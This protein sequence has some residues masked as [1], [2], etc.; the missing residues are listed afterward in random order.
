MTGVAGWNR[1][2]SDGETTSVNTGFGAHPAIADL[3]D[4]GHPE[5]LVVREYTS[6]LFGYGDFSVVMLD[7]EGNI[8]GESDRFVEG[9]MDY[10]TGVAVSMSA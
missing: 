4:D 1:A 5:V 7:Y 6:S 2:G 8:I 10:A 9:E 3:D